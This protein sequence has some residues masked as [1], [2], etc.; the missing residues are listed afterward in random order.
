MEFTAEHDEGL[1]VYDELRRR[2]TLFEMR[3]DGLLCGKR[4]RNVEED[5]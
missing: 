2:A 1:A 3:C 4:R 5:R